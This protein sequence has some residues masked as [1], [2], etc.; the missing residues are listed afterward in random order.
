MEFN[1]VDQIS[2]GIA[3][4]ILAIIGF[5]IE[6]LAKAEE[7]MSAIPTNICQAIFLY[8]VGAIACE[9]KA[10]TTQIADKLGLVSHDTL[11]KV[12]KSGKRVLG[13]LPI[14]LITFCLSQ[15]MGYLI[16]DDVLVPK[17][18]ASRIQGVY[19]EFDHA[20]N[21]H[22][23]G[24]RIVMLLWCN[25]QVRIPVAWAIWHKE[26][27]YF[28]GY[29]AK[30]QAKYQHTGECL[31][32]INGQTLP[33]QTKNQI[34]VD[35]LE[36]VLS[37][38][39][40]AEYI[41]FD[42]WYA[43]RDNLQMISE[44][45]FAI[46]LACY[47]RLKG[48]RKVVY[49]EREMTIEALNKLFP[50]TSFNHKHGAYLKA[51]DVEL[52]DYG[53]IKLLLVR[54]DTH[55]EPDK[56]KFLFS[57]DLQASAPQILLRY[58]TRWAIETIFRDLKQN[59]NLGSCQA[60]SLDAQTSHLAMVIFAFV[61]M[62]LLPDLEFKGR[63]FSSLG[64]KKKLLACLALFTNAEKTRFWVINAS[65]PNSRF[66]PLDESGLDKVGLRFVF[67]YETL[68]FPNCQRAA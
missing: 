16:I 17:R 12:L 35:L 28:L 67:A 40:K 1:E 38:G 30:G 21:E 62:E 19:N 48:N 5:S 33:Y 39:L 60:T 14:L 32:Q 65:R 50:I 25:G 66:V 51:V 57:T 37:R 2:E 56:T 23:K 42:S 18:Y 61:L 59:L 53:S 55:L 3:I 22:V 31:L 45:V 58:R 63:I 9:K 46:P 36:N 47:S 27:K 6:K 43:S 54:K 11:T 49:E 64:D 7:W 10:T 13:Q 44:N 34:A 8:M 20:D 52:P 24:M 15:T 41:T 68:L 26:K 29:T 4:L